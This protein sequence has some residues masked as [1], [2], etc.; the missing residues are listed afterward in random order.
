MLRLTSTTSSANNANSP[1]LRLP[2]ELKNQIYEA[3]LGGRLIHVDHKL[4]EDNFYHYLCKAKMSEMEAH[5]IFAASTEPWSAPEIKDRHSTCDDGQTVWRSCYECTAQ[6]GPTTA[7]HAGLSL[8]ILRCC[9]QIYQEARLL[10]L[11]ANTWSF[12]CPYDFLVYW[13]FGNSIPFTVDKMLAICQLH[14]HII[15]HDKFDMENWGEV[16]R[17]I[18]RNFKS[19]R[20]FYINIEQLHLEHQHFKKWQERTEDSFWGSLMELGQLDLRFVAV[21]ISDFHLLHSCFGSE[22]AKI[23]EYRW[24]MAQK[25]ECARDV[26]KVLLRK[27]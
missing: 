19:L 25:Q 11:S 16:F 26:E 24:T 12:A 21:T 5:E 18:A 14:L 13:S 2:Q 9:R 22:K 10:T 17:Q 1:L 7:L 23:S 4:E 8:S 20:Y 27:K 3:V 15:I 6:I